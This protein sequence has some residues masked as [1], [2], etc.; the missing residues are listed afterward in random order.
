MILTGE[1]FASQS[2]GEMASNITSSFTSLTK[3]VTAGSYLAGL[4]FSIG[5][6]MKFKQHKD[7]PTQIPI[8]TPIALLFIAAALLFLPSILGIAGETMFGGS[9]S[10]AGPGG[11]IFSSGS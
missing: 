2:L 8:G 6:I 10:T 3:L 4:G 9:A 7:N 11:M 5:A 1:A